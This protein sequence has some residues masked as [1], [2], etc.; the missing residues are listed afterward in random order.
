MNSP[1]DRVRGTALRILAPMNP[2]CLEDPGG[3]KV[4]RA[5]PCKGVKKGYDM[6]E[7]VSPFREGWI[8]EAEGTEDRGSY[9]VDILGDPREI[10]SNSHYPRWFRGVVR[11]EASQRR[12]IATRGNTNTLVGACRTL[13]E[14]ARNMLSWSDEL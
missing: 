9:C 8:R 7:S 3:T 10:A 13:R 5:K 2:G 11:A 14:L 4:H 12:D 1:A 6:V